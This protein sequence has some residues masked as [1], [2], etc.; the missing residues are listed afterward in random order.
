MLALFVEVGAFEAQGAGYVGHMEVVAADFGEE[1]FAFE[2]FR[3]LLE[4]SLPRC[5]VD[6]GSGA[7]GEFD[8]G[9]GLSDVIVANGVFG[10]E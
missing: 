1:D 6:G 2:G 4:S 9:E 10:G 5:G 7:H 3:A 8:G